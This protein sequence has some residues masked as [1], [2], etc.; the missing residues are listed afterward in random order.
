MTRNLYSLDLL[1]SL[2][3]VYEETIG[4][5]HPVSRDMKSDP[6]EARR[7]AS[8][9][10][11]PKGSGIPLPE[12]RAPDPKGDMTKHPTGHVVSKTISWG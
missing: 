1:H 8:L 7:G 5:K 3:Q 9:H 2:E 12:S 6:R 11:H 4:F 10:H